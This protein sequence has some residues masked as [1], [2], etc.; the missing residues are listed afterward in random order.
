MMTNN[1]NRRKI[2]GLTVRQWIVAAAIV[3]SVVIFGCRFCYNFVR[4]RIAPVGENNQNGGQNL[5]P[6]TSAPSGQLTVEQAANRYLMFGNPSNAAQT[7]AN[8]YLLVNQYYALSYNRSKGTPNWVAWTVSL[9]DLGNVDRA[10][11]FRPDDRLPQGFPRVTPADYTGSGFDRGHLCPSADR[12]ST[13][14]ANSA[15]FLMTN[16]T[17]Q[18]PDLNRNVWERLES[19]SRDL[20]RKGNDLYIIAGVYGDAGKIK[21][22][23]TIPTNDWKIVLVMP[24]GIENVSSV[25]QNTR[26]IAVDMP[27]ING[28]A[29]D[30]W[31]K[32]RTTVVQIEQKTGLNFFANL[33]PNVQNALK[34][35]MDNQ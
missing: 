5:P 14:E 9:N 20:V 27:N 21:R 30:D 25:N 33:P 13:P 8:N 35:K 3:V 6:R 34:S 10:N 32:Y 17:P 1:F 4:E 7:D 22:K 19:Y 2:Y 23:I 28:I 11:D 29:G 24:N 18:T 16:M 31:R 15:T 26:I 12:T